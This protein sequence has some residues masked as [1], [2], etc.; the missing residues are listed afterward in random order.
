MEK[1]Y[2]SRWRNKK[3][4][5]IVIKHRIKIKKKLEND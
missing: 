5:N 3:I 2:P 1:K 4:I